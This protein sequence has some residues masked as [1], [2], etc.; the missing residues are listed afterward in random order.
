MVFI[1]CLEQVSLVVLCLSSGHD[2]AKQIRCVIV[3]RGTEFFLQQVQFYLLRLC[4][5]KI[6][7]CVTERHF[8]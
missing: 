4:I 3:Q 5:N 2:T 6:L 1:I 7:K 8:P